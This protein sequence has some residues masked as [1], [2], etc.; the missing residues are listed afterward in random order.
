MIKWLKKI[1]LKSKPSIEQP[2]E[3][4]WYK[5]EQFSDGPISGT[6]YY[7]KDGSYLEILDIIP[8]PGF[9]SETFNKDEK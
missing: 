4:K 9:S 7:Y 8:D 1:F 5:I 2:K 3:R 6:R